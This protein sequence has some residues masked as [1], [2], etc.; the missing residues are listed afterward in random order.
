MTDHQKI[1]I[2]VKWRI[3]TTSTASPS[4]WGIASPYLEA[5]KE[6]V[7]FEKKKSVVKEV[8]HEI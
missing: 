4:N 2:F 5:A 8:I 3:R 7:E 6:V 1:H